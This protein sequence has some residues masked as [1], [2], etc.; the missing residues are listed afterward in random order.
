M[1][2]SSRHVRSDRW[3]LCRVAALVSGALC[4]PVM[5]SAAAQPGERVPACAGLEAGPTRT[6]ARVIDGETV[7]LDDGTQLRLIGALAPRAI[8]AGA[9]PGLWPL[10]IAAQEEL[11]A[12]ILGKSIEL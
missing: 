8:D 1:R 10:E 12:L 5:T 3:R 9:D 7:A 6:V 4:L 2:A 11:S